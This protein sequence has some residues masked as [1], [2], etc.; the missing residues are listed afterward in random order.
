MTCKAKPIKIRIDKCK[1]LRE[2]GTTKGMG[3]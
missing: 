3:P 2:L 1:H